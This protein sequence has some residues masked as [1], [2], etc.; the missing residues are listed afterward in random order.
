MLVTERALTKHN[1]RLAQIDHQLAAIE[2]EMAVI[3]KH[4][5]PASDDE[6]QQAMQATDRNTARLS[7]RPWGLLLRTS[8]P[9]QCYGERKSKGASRGAPGRRGARRLAPIDCKNVRLKPVS[10]WGF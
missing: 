1:R 6:F 7:R 10:E 4:L 3:D 5:L 8:K 9:P 2:R